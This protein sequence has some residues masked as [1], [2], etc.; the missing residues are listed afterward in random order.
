[1]KVVQQ[2][3]EVASRSDGAT[4]REAGRGADVACVRLGW[5]ETEEMLPSSKRKY[6]GR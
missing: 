1:L 6:I 3:G 2:K 4:T 5:I